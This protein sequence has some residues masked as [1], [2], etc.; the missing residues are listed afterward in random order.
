M[1]MG[2]LYVI[3]YFTSWLNG[4]INIENVQCNIFLLAG[5]AA[6]YRPD[7]PV[8]YP[9]HIHVHI[10]SSIRHLQFKTRNEEVIM[11]SDDLWQIERQTKTLILFSFVPATDISQARAVA[12]GNVI[13]AV[14]FL[15]GNMRFPTCRPG[16]IKG[17][18]RTIFGIR[19]NVGET[20]KHIEF[21]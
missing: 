13:Q 9:A 16:K 10:D 1:T 8:S 14:G 3:L 19:N 6:H 15:K 4:A 11:R 20:Y 12:H 21:G 2:K 17:N 18:F 5:H 7:G